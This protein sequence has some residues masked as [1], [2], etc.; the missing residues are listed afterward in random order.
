[1]RSSSPRADLR[2]LLVLLAVLQRIEEE[3][4]GLSIAVVLLEAVDEVLLVHGAHLIPLRGLRL[5]LVLLRGML[6]AATAD[7]LRH[8]SNRAM[9]HGASR[10]ERKSLGDGAQKT[11]HHST[12]LL[13]LHRGL[14]IQRKKEKG[15]GTC[16]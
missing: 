4:A 10:A 16:D 8:R 7:A 12:A 14:Q 9:C 2:E 3:L 13:L 6:L 15:S 11:A 1:M 5:H